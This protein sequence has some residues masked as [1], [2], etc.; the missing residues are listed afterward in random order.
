MQESERKFVKLK[1]KKMFL[2]FLYISER[3]SL[4]SILG[5]YYT[6]WCT[7]IKKLG[8][9]QRKG[10]ENI[11]LPQGINSNLNLGIWIRIA[12]TIKIIISILL[13]T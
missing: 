7:Q 2:T 6:M 1:T 4:S 9:N 5:Y 10:E 8:F 12:D 11:L 13:S 3:R